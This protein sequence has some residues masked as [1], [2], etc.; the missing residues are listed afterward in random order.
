M[1]PSARRRAPRSIFTRVTAR[2]IARL[3]EVAFVTRLRPIRLPVEVA[4]QLTLALVNRMPFAGGQHIV[5]GLVLPLLF[6][7]HF[8]VALPA[9]KSHERG[10][11]L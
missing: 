2:W 5:I 3:P 10:G 8:P 7:A 4:R 9:S 1:I 11:I 6:S